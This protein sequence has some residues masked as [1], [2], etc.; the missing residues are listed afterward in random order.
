[1][2]GVGVCRHNH[3]PESLFRRRPAHE[4]SP[5]STQGRGGERGGS[6]PVGEASPAPPALALVVYALCGHGRGHSSRAAAVAEALRARGHRVRFAADAPAAD[7][8]AQEGSGPVHRVP[9]LR[10][11]L[12]GNR[13]RYLATARANLDLTWR[14]P[15]IIAEAE[16]WL[17]SVE[18]DVV[19][20]DHEPFV[21]RA[22]RRLGV[23]VVA[24]SHQLVLT[25]ARP[26]VPLR[27]ALSAV[28]TRLGIGV[29][30]PPRPDGVVVPSFF[31]PPPRA[32]SRAVFVP[33]IL[34]DDVLAVRPEPGDR[35]L[36][37]VNEGAGLEPLVR[38]LGAVDAAFDVYGLDPGQAAPPNVRLRPPSR[39]GF[40]ADLGA[41]RAVVAT[42][43][44]T[45]LSEA[46]HLGV[47][48]LALPNRGFFEQ[49]VNALALRDAGRGGAVVGRP[50]RPSDVAV[51]LDRAA[52]LRRPAQT[53]A[54]G[55]AGRERAADA[56]EAVVSGAG[57]PAP[58]RA[59]VRPEVA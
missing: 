34:R 54:E 42:A 55:R 9:A 28:G 46:L 39:A 23:P 17:A 59:P 58:T 21:A 25:E 57:R 24:L 29:L 35:V 51:F 36:V 1:M 18:A 38:T 32:G 53:A 37:Y 19:V 16:A 20:S 30:A 48:V 2:G 49:V 27:H 40:L 56:I 12:R 14:S 45:L 22:A 41:A 7:R 31:F 6:A 3:S 33:P 44:F 8:L 11:V 43:G 4:P 26:R 5:A 50:P 10:Q 13:V 47:P 15:E 52:G